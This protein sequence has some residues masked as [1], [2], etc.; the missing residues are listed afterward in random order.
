VCCVYATYFG[1]RI[2]YRNNVDLFAWGERGELERAAR[3][4]TMFS[5]RDSN[6]STLCFIAITTFG[7]NV[8]PLV[9]GNWHDL[10]ILN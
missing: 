2:K 4:V 6:W 5:S 1:D 7:V 10:N 9:S 8:V 3:E